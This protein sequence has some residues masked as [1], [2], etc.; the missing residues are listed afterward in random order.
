M[1]KYFYIIISILGFIFLT[2]VVFF[3]SE[4]YASKWE[5]ERL[6]EVNLRDTSGKPWRIADLKNKFGIIYFGYT[7]CPDICPTALSDLI[8]ALTGMGHDQHLFQPIFVSID[9]ERD[10]QQIIKEYI[11]HF[12]HKLLGLTGTPTQLKSFTFNIGSTYASQKKGANDQDY[13]VNHTVGYF[14][15]SSTGQKIRV[16]TESNPQDLRRM[17]LRVKNRMSENIASER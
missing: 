10:T 9:P 8:T 5:S 7:Y 14:M 2:V 1:R 15:I 12:D 13:I 17:I 4:F 16:P 6:Q 3:T 11:L